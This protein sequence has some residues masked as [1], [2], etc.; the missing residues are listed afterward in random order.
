LPIAKNMKSI[1]K[2]LETSG[3]SDCDS[4]GQTLTLTLPNP[5]PGGPPAML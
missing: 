3:N 4:E 1:W 5:G 2:H